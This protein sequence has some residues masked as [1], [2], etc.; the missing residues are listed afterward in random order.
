MKPAFNLLKIESPDRKSPAGFAV[1]FQ[2]YVLKRK[3]RSTYDACHVAVRAF[4]FHLVKVHCLVHFLIGIPHNDG[5]P[6]ELRN[7]QANRRVMWPTA[8]GVSWHRNSG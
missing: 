1:S 6:R 5:V 7:S 2:A 3:P 8:K 4:V